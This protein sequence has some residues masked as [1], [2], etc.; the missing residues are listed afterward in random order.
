MESIAK[1]QFFTEIVVLRFGVE[2]SRVVEA[3]GAVFLVAALQTGLKIDIFSCALGEAPGSQ[4][5]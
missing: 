2:F 3:L 4:A 1:K 5:C